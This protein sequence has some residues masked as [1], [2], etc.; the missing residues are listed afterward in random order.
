[1]EFDFEA[2]GIE[3]KYLVIIEPTGTG[4]SAYVPDLPGCVGGARTLDEIRQLMAEAITG[5]IEVMREFGETVPQPTA[6][7]DMLEVPVLIA[8]D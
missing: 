3:V 6:L 1:L 2:G 5:H 4:Y 7:S 8:S